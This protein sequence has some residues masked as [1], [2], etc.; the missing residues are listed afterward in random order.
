MGERE[1]SQSTSV[2]QV[3][4]KVQKS[5]KT[6]SPNQVSAE[7]G[8]PVLKC[9]GGV[10]WEPQTQKVIQGR[11]FERGGRGLAAEQRKSRG[12]GSHRGGGFAW[13]P[14]EG[15]KPPGMYLVDVP[16]P[17]PTL[18]SMLRWKPCAV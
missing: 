6:G 1:G 18:V 9:V 11:A 13:I 12:W 10:G 17:V 14:N 5:C 15:E 8:G 2:L 3:A 16:A 4:D 7:P